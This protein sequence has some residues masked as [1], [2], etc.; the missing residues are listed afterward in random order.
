MTT[1]T[2][3]APAVLS[4]IAK[5]VVQLLAGVVA[6]LGVTL[7]DGAASPLEVVNLL[8]FVVSAWGV[9]QFAGATAKT[10]VA[11]IAVVLQ[12]VVALIPAAVG[13][14]DLGSIDWTAV[15]VAALAALATGI[16]PNVQSK[17]A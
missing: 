3:P 14:T 15:I 8:L 16:V 2:T 7:S 4:P 12:A 11:T 6:L 17:S 5:A 13:W 10:V 1:P 9:W